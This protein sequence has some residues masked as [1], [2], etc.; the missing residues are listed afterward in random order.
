SSIDHLVNFFHHE[1][2]HIL[3]LRH[4][5]APV[6]EPYDKSVRLGPKNPMSIM[7]SSAPSS[8]YVDDLDKTWLRQFYAYKKPIHKKLAI[9]D[10]TA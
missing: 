7:N 1:I 8:L 4:E 9:I 5:L 2:G 6:K 10:V 3:G